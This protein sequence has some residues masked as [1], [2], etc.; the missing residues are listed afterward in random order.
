M[1][2]PAGNFTSIRIVD[3]LI[4]ITFDTL[5]MKFTVVPE[6]AIAFIISPKLLWVDAFAVI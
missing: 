3:F 2:Y 6:S 1:I 5:G 4:L